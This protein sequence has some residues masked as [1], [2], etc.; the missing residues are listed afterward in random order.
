[1][2]ESG[3]MAGLRRQAVKMTNELLDATKKEN[4]KQKQKTEVSVITFDYPNNIKYVYK[5]KNIETTARKITL[6]DY[7][8]RGST[9]LFDAT[10]EAINNGL[11]SAFADD[12]ETSFLVLVVTDGGENASA[13]YNGNTL[14][15][16]FKKV[17]KTL[18]WT[19]AFQVPKGGKDQ[20]I[21]M[22]I[23]PDNIREWEATEEGIKDATWM[24]SA[25]LTRYYDSRSRGI[26]SVA[27]FYVETD[28]SN[29]TQR[30]L[31]REL[32]D[33]SD[34]Y[35]IFSVPHEQQIR[36]FVEGKTHETYEKGQA[37]YQL[38][39]PELVQADKE[40]LVFDKSNTQ[41]YGGDEA[42]D[43]IG[44]PI[45]ANAK[46]KP[47]DHGNY[48]IFVQSNSVNRKLLKGNKVAVRMS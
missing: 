8:P 26:K 33:L 23:S 48:E 29:L 3:S 47:G 41:L 16:L 5:N 6:E 38:V 17:Q 18:R 10:G 35:G 22:G 12:D 34:D 42:R 2:D 21:R 43:L 7:N 11:E 15:T 27:D 30:Q 32:E 31:K 25:G 19:I 36:D 14:S 28:L 39:K 1:M 9:A 20:L 46:V 13:K 45:G 40:V 4:K 24:A 44:L 37:F